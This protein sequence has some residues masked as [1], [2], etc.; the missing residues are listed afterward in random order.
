MTGAACA[1]Y[2]SNKN[3]VYAGTE[4]GDECYCGNMI[5][6]PSALQNDTKC[7]MGCSGNS[8]EACGGMSSSNAV[9]VALLANI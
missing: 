8:S 7:N 2:C 1:A 4:Y 5:G 3:F 6:A 9:S